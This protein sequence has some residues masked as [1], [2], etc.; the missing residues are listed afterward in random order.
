MNVAVDKKMGLPEFIVCHPLRDPADAG[1][2]YVYSIVEKAE[3]LYSNFRRLLG[4]IIEGRVDMNVRA[5]V[6]F[7]VVYCVRYLNFN[8]IG[9]PGLYPDIN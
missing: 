7:K 3:D 9:H 2:G 8:W 5:A 6:R 1:Y 4:E